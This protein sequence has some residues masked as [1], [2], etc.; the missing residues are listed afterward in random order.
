MTT[1]GFRAPLAALMLSIVAGCSGDT[2]VRPAVAPSDPAAARGAPERRLAI[3]LATTD[4][5][6]AGMIFS[7]EGPNITG[8]TAAPGYQLV[9][10]QTDERNPARID[11]LLIGPLGTGVVAWLHTRGVNSGSPY[12]AEVTQVAAGAA[13]NFAPRQAPGA[14]SVQMRRER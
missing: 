6:D 13:E 12:T 1:H 4:T 14:Y 3:E 10:R 5:G 11:V 8:I 2:S 9:H 7:I